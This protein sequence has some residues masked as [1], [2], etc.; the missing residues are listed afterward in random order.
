M[1]IPIRLMDMGFTEGEGFKPS[2]SISE[3]N[4]GEGDQ[5]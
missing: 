5:Q 1:S 3:Y 4:Q 2:P